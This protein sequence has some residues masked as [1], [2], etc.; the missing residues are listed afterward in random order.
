[1]I[2]SNSREYH[3][4]SYW[5]PSG[6][7]QVG[8]IKRNHDK[9]MGTAC[10]QVST[11]AGRPDLMYQNFKVTPWHVKGKPAPAM[12]AMGI[13]LNVHNHVSSS[14]DAR[15]PLGGGD[16][17]VSRAPFCEREVE[18]VDVEYVLTS[19]SFQKVSVHYTSSV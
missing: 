18:A 12:S 16:V 14:L 9:K 19:L 8:A 2:S 5:I 7:P 10:N 15:R 6:F 17:V 11:D 1:M 3:I 13:P 4:P